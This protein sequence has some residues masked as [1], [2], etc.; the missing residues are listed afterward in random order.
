MTFAAGIVFAA[1]VG[2]HAGGAPSPNIFAS[3]AVALVLAV[4]LAIGA[5]LGFHYSQLNSETRL[6]RGFTRASALIVA[7]SAAYLLAALDQRALHQKNVWFALVVS[8]VL[9][10]AVA[11]LLVRAVERGE[12]TAHLAPA[13]TPGESV[14]LC[15]SSAAYA[16]TIIDIESTAERVDRMVKRVSAIFKDPAAVQ[17]IAER[18]FGPGSR[19]ATAYIDEHRERHRLFVERLAHH[20]TTCREIYNRDE[21]L[22]YVRSPSHGI[23][24]V[25]ERDYLRRTLTEWLRCL[26]TYD[27]YHVGITTD[28]T[29]LK[30][31]VYDEARVVLHE[32]AGSLDG[33]RLNAIIID[34]RG[35]AAAFQTDFENVWERIPA[36]MRSRLEVAAFIESELL[37]LVVE[38]DQGAV[39]KRRSAGPR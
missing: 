21:L 33:Q 38:P 34:G 6:R 3:G 9:L 23:D 22:R 37:P 25:L 10:V 36:H 29:P 4:A 16:R 12:E 8:A 39:R 13:V 19:Q 28:P 31:Q 14:Q 30:Y 15:A 2:H 1:A 11:A 32:A 35:A 24:I 17:A 26:R 20:D 5:P 18:R 7:L 27:N